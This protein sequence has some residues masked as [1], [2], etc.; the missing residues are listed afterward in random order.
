MEMNLNVG[1]VS[2]AGPA[3]LRCVRGHLGDGE[4]TARFQQV[5]P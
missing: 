2:T 1:A 4:L 3:F 5:H